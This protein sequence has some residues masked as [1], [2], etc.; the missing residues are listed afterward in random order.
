M[1]KLKSQNCNFSYLIV[2]SKITLQQTSHLTCQAIRL[3]KL[4]LSLVKFGSQTNLYVG[5]YIEMRCYM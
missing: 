4:T 3:S 2:N 5:E 1:V